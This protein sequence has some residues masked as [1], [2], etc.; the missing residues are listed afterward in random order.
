MTERDKIDD[1][2]NFTRSE[3][4]KKVSELQAYLTAND[5]PK[6]WGLFSERFRQEIPLEKFSQINWIKDH[7]GRSFITRLK[8]KDIKSKDGKSSIVEF[9]NANIVLC[10]STDKQGQLW[11]EDLAGKTIKKSKNILPNEIDKQD[12]IVS[13]KLSEVLKRFRGYQEAISKRDLRNQMGYFLR[14][15][16]EKSFSRWGINKAIAKNKGLHDKISHTQ[17]IKMRTNK[18]E[19]SVTV[20]IEGLSYIWIWKKDSGDGWKI[21]KIV[22]SDGMDFN[23]SDLPKFYFEDSN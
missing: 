14:V 23:P 9:Y 13:Q 6:V 12:K 20:E 11:L 4:M 3:I 21:S 22:A 7:D 5:L 10:I 17:D 18:L 15:G 16:S 2:D 1:T 19:P 8:P